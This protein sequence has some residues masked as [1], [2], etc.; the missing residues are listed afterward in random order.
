MSSALTLYTI[1]C[2]KRVE[3]MKKTS[4][5]SELKQSSGKWVLCCTFDS[6]SAEEIYKR[7]SD[8]LIAKKINQCRYIKSIKRRNNYDGTQEIT[9]TYINSVRNIYT[10]PCN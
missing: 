9:V 5:C 1:D 3:T 2:R 4:M 6:M 10:V 8:D 7:L